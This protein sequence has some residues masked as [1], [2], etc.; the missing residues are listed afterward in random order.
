MTK[1]IF[2]SA[3]LDDVEGERPASKKALAALQSTIEAVYRR[4][5]AGEEE[6]RVIE[7][8]EERLELFLD[9]VSASI[10]RLRGEGDSIN[11]ESN[12]IS[13]RDLFI[14]KNG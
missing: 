14:S 6:F 2:S 1:T 9:E 12:R 13:A 8:V 11:T 7:A 3:G 5:C 10:P 4:D